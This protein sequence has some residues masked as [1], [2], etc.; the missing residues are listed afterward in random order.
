MPFVKSLHPWGSSNTPTPI[1][2]H[3]SNCEVYGIQITNHGSVMCLNIGGVHIGAFVTIV[4][5]AKSRMAAPAKIML[6]AFTEFIISSNGS[7]CRL[8]SDQVHPGVP[9]HTLATYRPLTP[10]IGLWRGDARWRRF[11]PGV[12]S[13]P[14]LRE[15]RRLDHQGYRQC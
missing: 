4:A 2:I 5:D 6:K 13:K 3:L 10:S 8:Y 11:T 9:G 1:N 12:G 15:T 14:P 7:Q